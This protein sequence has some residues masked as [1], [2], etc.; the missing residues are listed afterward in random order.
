VSIRETTEFRQSQLGAGA[1]NV[2]P[3]RDYRTHP[4][5]SVRIAKRRMVDR[6]PVSEVTKTEELARLK[7][8]RVAQKKFQQKKESSDEDSEL[9]EPRDYQ[10]VRRG[11]KGPLLAPRGY[12]FKEEEV[13]EEED[14]LPEMGVLAEPAS[15]REMFS[16]HSFFES[17]IPLA[18]EAPALLEA[19]ER[20]DFK[21]MEG[22]LRSVPID[23]VTEFR[24]YSRLLSK[25]VRG[26][27][28]ENDV[29]T[30]LRVVFTSRIRPEVEVLSEVVF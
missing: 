27:I 2:I 7:V 5:R 25:F 12:G 28:Q 23:R 11:G 8:S 24:A 18:P 10:R 9:S 26:K 1:G 22:I 19:V 4:R 15:P 3:Q 20:H 29:L 14:E 21:T 16:T 17:R 30:R 13:E 6:S